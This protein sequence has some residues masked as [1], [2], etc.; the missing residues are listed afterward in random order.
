MLGTIESMMAIRAYKENNNIIREF[1][2]ILHNAEII[3]RDGTEEVYHEL[4]EFS[5]EKTSDSNIGIG[6][7][8]A[9]PTAAMRKLGLHYNYSPIFQ[10]FVYQNECLI[11]NDKPMI[12]IIGRIKD[13]LK[14]ETSIEID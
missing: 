2:G 13:S 1:D 7:T 11:I 3:V 5:F 14:E 8:W 12:I 4:T 6:I 10:E 9:L